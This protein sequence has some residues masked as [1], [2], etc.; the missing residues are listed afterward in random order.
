MQLERIKAKSRSAQAPDNSRYDSADGIVLFVR[1]VLGVDLADYQVEALQGFYNH[2]RA[3][4]RAPHGV[5]KTALASWVVLWGISVFPDDV[6]IPCTASKWRQLTKFLFPEIRKWARRADWTKVGMTLRLGKEILEQAI[7]LE[8]K[9]AFAIASNDATAIEGAHAKY[10]IYIFDEAKAIPADIWDSA[11]GA[12]STAGDD[13]EGRAYALAISTPGQPSGRFYDIHKQKQGYR[14]WWT[15]HITLEQAI[16]AGQISQQWADERAK[17]WGKNSAVYKNRVLGEFDESGEHAV[18]PLEWIEAS[19]NRYLEWLD[20]GGVPSGKKAYGVDVARYGEDK[21]VICEIIGKVVTQMVSRSKQSTMVTAGEV[22]TLLDKQT[23]CY[24]DVI[25]VGA[26]VVDRLRELGYKKVL[27]V[28]VS[29]KTNITDKSGEIGFPNLRSALWW[30]LREALD[31]DGDILLAIPPDDDLTGDL[32]APAYEYTSN[33]HYKV[34][35]KDDMRKRISRSPDKADAL[36]L[37]YYALY[38]KPL[39]DIAILG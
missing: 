8:G 31:P 13:T 11:E 19:N 20:S 30:I 3:S 26:G 17:A 38:K 5:G 29:H 35:S 12:F 27:G 6:K 16:N 24:I 18:I 36:A 32:S 9:E 2:G 10:L 15:Q 14:E 7:K 4:I 21:T 25:G 33:G 34:E 28:N 1:E 37:A 23:R 39:A 22:S